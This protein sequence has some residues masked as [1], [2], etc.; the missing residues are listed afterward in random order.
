MSD[1]VWPT[2]PPLAGVTSLVEELRRRMP[3]RCFVEAS[4]MDAGPAP[5]AVVFVVSAIAPL[6]ESDCA[7]ADLATAKTDA[8]VAVVSK[9][10]VHR[11]WRG[12]LS[13]DRERLGE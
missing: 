9:V 8:G 12:V 13:A 2:G 10:D 1:V 3:G 7:L 11:D 4:E 6:T 5:A